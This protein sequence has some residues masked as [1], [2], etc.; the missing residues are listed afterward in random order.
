MRIILNK[1]AHSTVFIDDSE[2]GIVTK[3]QNNPE[4]DPGY[5]HRQSRGYEIIDSIKSH[6]SDIG[7][8]LPELVEIKNMGNKQIIKEKII[9]GKAFDVST[10][11]SLS[12]KQKNNIAKQMAIFLNAMHS[13]YE[14]KPATE[15]IKNMNKGKLNNAEDIIAKFDGKL[16]EDISNRL[17]QAE[18]YLLTA[19]ISDEVIVMTHKDLRTSNIMYD[20]STGKIAVIDFEL[21][22]L[23]NVY[24]DFVAFAPA[25]SMPWDF[26]KRV[27]DFYNKIPDKKYPI[28]INPEKVQNMLLYGT[29]HE[30]A[31][32]VRPEDIKNT[33]KQ[34]IDNL[35]N[36]LGTVTG[37]H[38]DKKSIFENAIK[39]VP[40]TNNYIKPDLGHDM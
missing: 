26:T 22:G 19:D 15:S 7:V 35:I 39:K 12:E 4:K 18:Q 33:T 36:Q 3:E 2:P 6:N 30:F 40:K 28:N 31:R 38:F 9:P 21:A 24:H 10:Y 20:E 11:L 25:S 29:M 16:P 37:I 27:I 32:C 1:G 23:D 5:L 17:K 8:F 13:S 34:D 14:C